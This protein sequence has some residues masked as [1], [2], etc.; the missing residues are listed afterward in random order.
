MN[1]TETMLIKLMIAVRD[2][3]NATSSS[4]VVINVDNIND[5][6]IATSIDM[7]FSINSILLDFNEFIYDIDQDSLTVRTIP[8][9]PNSPNPSL[10]QNRLCRYSIMPSTPP[11]RH[12]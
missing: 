7:P 1:G 12:W 5:P 10:P 9:S 4:E 2:I 8:P 6:P 11:P 3:D